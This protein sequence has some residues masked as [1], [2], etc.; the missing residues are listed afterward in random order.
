MDM[1]QRASLDPE[2]EPVWGTDREEGGW[3]ACGAGGGRQDGRN[4][5][6]AGIPMDN[7][8]QAQRC[9][10]RGTCPRP[11]QGPTLSP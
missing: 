7:D 8:L 5:L 1:I 3:T 6:L 9:C 2:G 4:P 11:E 10:C